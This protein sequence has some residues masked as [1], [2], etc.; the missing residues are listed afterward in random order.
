M[1]VVVLADSRDIVH[2]NRS[3]LASCG[4][5]LARTFASHNE[6]E[7]I[8]ACWSCSNGRKVPRKSNDRTPEPANASVAWLRVHDAETAADEGNSG[9]SYIPFCSRQR[10]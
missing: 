1:V 5:C 10:R 3:Q 2:G 4:A 9:D 8:L 7:Y 6:S